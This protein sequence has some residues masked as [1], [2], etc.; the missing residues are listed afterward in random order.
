[1]AKDN[2]RATQWKK[3]QSGN[4]KGRPPNTTSLTAL[5]R[6]EMN[7][8]CPLINPKTQQPYNKTW[9]EL[10]V[11]ATMSL[12]IQGNATALREV[13]ER[14]DG[15]VLHAALGPIEGSMAHPAEDPVEKLIA[16]L[17]EVKARSVALLPAGQADSAP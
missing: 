2:Q 14:F 17:A 13:W 4:P 11:M 6:Q 7:N 16:K 15:R 9:S 8:L 3:G 1:L 12:A 5:R 10:I